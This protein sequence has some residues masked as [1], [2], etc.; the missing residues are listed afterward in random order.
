MQYVTQHSEDFQISTNRDV[1]W[2]EVADLG[3]KNGIDIR[4]HDPVT[5]QLCF[6]IVALDPENCPLI[7]KAP[8]SDA[9]FGAFC[10]AMNC[11]SDIR[12]ICVLIH[13]YRCEPMLH[14]PDLESDGRDSRVYKMVEDIVDEIQTH[15]P[16]TMINVA[17]R[18]V[19]GVMTSLM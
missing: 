7:G 5:S 8:E 3:P 6:E 4:V 11:V 17:M 2:L 15:R 14:D 18:D 9:T 1:G 19:G 13:F 16:G 10:R 12:Q